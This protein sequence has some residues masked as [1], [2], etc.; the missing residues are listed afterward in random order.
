MFSKHSLPNGILSTVQNKLI[1]LI[2]LLI[3]FILAAQ[4]WY[5]PVQFYLPI[6][7]RSRVFRYLGL[8]FL[9]FQHKL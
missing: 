7:G 9:Q 2:H 1:M 3:Q 4:S 8:Q 6:N 5:V